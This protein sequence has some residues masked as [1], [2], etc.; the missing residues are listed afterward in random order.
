MPFAPEPPFKHGQPQ[1]TG[2][3]Y[4]NLGTPDAPTAPAVRRYLAQ[5]LSDP[6]VVEIPRVAWLPILY[7]AILP[8]RPARS[9]AKYA[10][11]WTKDGSPLKLWTQKQA[12][13]AVDEVSIARAISRAQIA[14]VCDGPKS[15]ARGIGMASEE[16]ADHFILS[17]QP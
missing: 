8:L 5:F 16:C 10:A 4:C 1:L 9:A 15:M 2:V 13:L 6:R 11:I 12:T 14:A 17:V 7:G 3:L